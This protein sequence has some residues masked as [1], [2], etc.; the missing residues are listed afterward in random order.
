MWK[1]GVGYGG[2]KGLFYFDMSSCFIG[3][4]VRCQEVDSACTGSNSGTLLTVSLTVESR[5][6]YDSRFFPASSSSVG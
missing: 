2:K 4:L 6:S 1:D 3:G 5:H